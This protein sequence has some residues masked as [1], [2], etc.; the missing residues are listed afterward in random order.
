MVRLRF[1]TPSSPF[2]T[3]QV[4][5]SEAGGPCLR[6]TARDPSEGLCFLRGPSPGDQGLQTVNAQIWLDTP[7]VSRSTYWSRFPVVSRPLYGVSTHFAE[8]QCDISS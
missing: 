8:D 7:H 5:R 4:G 1:G 6:V 2:V 3:L